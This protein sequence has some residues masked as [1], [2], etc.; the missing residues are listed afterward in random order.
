M[1]K[2]KLNKIIIKSIAIAS[3]LTM[4]TPSI[5]TANR[6]TQTVTSRDPDTN[7][8]GGS[9]K[10]VIVL[11]PGHGKSSSL[12]S[13]SEKTSEGFVKN[14][15][16]AWGEWRHFKNGTY[17]ESCE[18]TGCT[19]SHPSGGSCWYSI[20]QGDR[21]KEVGI[22]LNNANAAKK[23]LEQMGYEV[24]MTRTSNEQHPSFT[25]RATYCFPDGDTSKE[26]D[27]EL[28]VCIHSNAGGGQG[29]SYIATE[30]SYTQKYIPSDYVTRSNKAGDLINKKVAS[31]SGLRENSPLTGQG[32]LIAFNK[33]PVP[34]AYLEIGFS[35]N[36][37]DLSIL[38]SKSDAIGKAIAEGIDE[39]L[40]S[41]TPLTTGSKGSG[42]GSSSNTVNASKGKITISSNEEKFLG[43]WKNSEGKYIPY[44]S[45]PDKAKF[46]PDGK[47]VKY[48]N[49]ANVAAS[50]YNAD[51]WL[52]DLLSS[53]ER[54]QEHEK[55]MKYL[56][57]KYNRKRLWCNN[58]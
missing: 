2:N 22:N 17:G 26:P 33:N 55:L 25:K 4:L 21:D 43:L 15:S 35:D 49:Y 31:A 8:Q 27:A 18:G 30:K 48:R 52:F 16:G 23:Y 39:Y 36:A 29:T 7:S 58:I 6:F 51:Q 54:T 20:G 9:G 24:R 11:D 10:T 53:N 41:V 44:Y 12:M 50:I 5:I 32:Y 40:K 1:V 46:N 45:D 57:Y 42:T 37:S 19:G 47:S 56:M 14:S 13:D 28:Y 34:T 38:Q 3:L